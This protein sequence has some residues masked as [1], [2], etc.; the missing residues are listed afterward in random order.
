MGRDS[1]HRNIMGTTWMPP[2]HVITVHGSVLLTP[3]QTNTTTIRM[4][5]A[6]PAIIDLPP[7]TPR[8]LG[9]RSR[10]DK[11][12]VGSVTIR[13]PGTHVIADSVPGGT[14]SNTQA[15][16][17]QWSVELEVAEEGRWTVVAVAGVWRTT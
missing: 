3:K 11:A 15:G 1:E 16:A 8:M 5:S 10:V 9:W 12:G 6:V 13:A 17:H 4:D 2:R 14:I 7:A